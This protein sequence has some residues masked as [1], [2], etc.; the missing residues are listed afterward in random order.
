[1]QILIVYRYFHPDTPP[2]ASMLKRLSA[3]MAAAGHDVTVV[4]AQPS[5]KS[6]VDITKQPWSEVIDG[7]AVRRIWLFPERGMGLAKI[8]NSAIFVL[9][10]FFF[11]LTGR[12]YDLVWTATQP[13]ILQAFFL[14][15]AARL[16]GSQFL[17]HLQDIH[18][19]IAVANA[20]GDQ[21]LGAIARV[22][23]WM[24][25]SSNNRAK[26]NVVIG[27]DMKQVLL[28][29]GVAQNKVHVVRNFALGAIKPA[30]TPR[31]QSDGPARLIFA[32]NIGRFQNLGALVEA[33]KMLSPAEATLTFLG[34]GHA[35]KGLIEQ[36]EKFP[37]GQIVFR[38]HVDQ[39]QALSIM[40]DHDV[41]VITLTPGIFRYAFPSKLWTYMAANLQTIAMVEEDSDLAKFLTRHGV[42]KAVSWKRSPAEIS[43]AIRSVIDVARTQ[44]SGPASKP[45]LFAPEFAK[46]RWL[47]VLQHIEH[48]DP[49]TG[50]KDVEL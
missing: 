36:V 35:K 15:V 20:G 48:S 3:W 16:R 30:S 14:S 39:D 26:L 24:D 8:V 28:D 5:Y 50:L 43:D 31:C 2:Y 32:G 18:P 4:T 37:K 19:E 7:V 17:Y 45:Q 11:V 21:K 10:S 23:R 46:E 41:G 22:L 38:P 29:R 12:K 6:N 44:R 42:G 33:F 49:A 34:D 13:P 40:S 27:N 25:K 1:M 47:S 9:V